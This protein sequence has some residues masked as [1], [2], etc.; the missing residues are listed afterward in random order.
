MEISCEV[1]KGGKDLSV[2]PVNKAISHEFNEGEVIVLDGSLR[3]QHGFSGDEVETA[4]HQYVPNTGLEKKLLHKVD[5][6]LIPMLWLMCVMAYVDRNNIVCSLCLQE[7]IHTNV[8]QGNANAAGMSDDIGLSDNR[9]AHTMPV[10]ERLVAHACRPEYA[11]L[12]S[13]FFVGY[14]L[15]EVPS[16]MILARV[17]PS[18]YLSG[19]MA[20]SQPSL[21][22][23][24][25]HMSGGP[26]NRTYTD[27]VI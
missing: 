19:L 14:L 6:S 5:L 22:H 16:N 7:E 15:W 13:I 9:K 17:R 24:H 10:L 8:D 26:G 11:L 18:W 27:G 25:T 12:I 23:T 21:A 20:V 1:G 2:A 3:G 4:L